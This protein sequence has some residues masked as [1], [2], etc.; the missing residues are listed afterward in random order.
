MHMY[1]GLQSEP[2]Y[3]NRK[4]IIH[5][6]SFDSRKEG[7]RYLVLLDMQKKG[8]ISDLELQPPFVLQ[9]SYKYK[10]KIMRELKYIADFKYKDQ[11]GNVIIEDVKGVRTQ[12]YLIKKK[13]FLYKFGE[14]YLFKET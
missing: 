4:M 3:K 1:K 7:R 5:G 2:K 14:E 12:S 10:G 9:E 11:D 8:E 6:I 13:I